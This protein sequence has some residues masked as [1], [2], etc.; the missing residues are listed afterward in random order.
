MTNHFTDM[1]NSDVIFVCGGNPAENHPAS[2]R[3]IMNARDKGAKLIVVD[4][5]YTRTAAV[6]D[7]YYPLR[8]GTDITLFGAII[9]YLIQNDLINHEYVTSYTNATWLIG[10]GYDFNDGM[11]S[12][13]TEDDKGKAKYDNTKWAYQVESETDWDTAP[14]APF[15]WA[16]AP[17]VPK[18]TT[19]KV[20]NVKKD[21]TMQDP[22]CVF[23][24]M[25]KHYERYTPQMVEDICG[26][27]KEQFKEVADA[28]GSTCT[29]DR[30]ATWLYAMGITQHTYGSQNIRAFSL[31]Q[32]LLGNI[33]IAGGGINALR[34]EANVQGS[35][36]WGLLADNLPSYLA[37][38]N[39]E[40]N[41]TLEAY[42]TKTT[43][44]AGY[45]SNRPK[46]LVSY[47]KEMYGPAA[48]LENEFCYQYLPKVEGSVN[49]TYM[50]IFE[51]LA[52]KKMNGML[53]FGQN[54]ALGGPNGNFARNA[55]KNLE[56]L[57]AIDLFMTDTAE[58]WNLPI[59]SGGKANPKAV[60][61]E[62]YFLPACSHI[63]KEGTTANSGR[64]IQWRYQAVKPLGESKD[65]GQIMSLLVEELKRLYAEEGGALP[66]AITDL[67][68]DYLDEN[69]H[70]S[71]RKAASA[72]NGYTT[73]DGKRILNLSKLQADGST[74]CIGWIYSGYFNN[75]D[76]DNPAD[77]PCGS[78]SREDVTISGG[79]G[80]L[81]SFTKWAWSWPMNRRVLYNR[82]STIKATG[83]A[84]NP[85]R[86]LVEWNP[87]VGNWDRNDVPDFGFQTAMPDGTN[88][89]NPPEKCPGFFMNSELVGRFF[90]PGL[91]DGPFPEHYEPIESP[92]KNKMS[93]QENNPA[94]LVLESSKRGSAKEYPIICTT[95]RVVEH[96]QTGASTRQSPWVAQSMPHMFLEI[97]V[98]L[99]KEKGIENGDKVEIFNNR[100]KITVFAMVTNRIR[101]FK[102]DGKDIYEVAM[103][104][105]WG[106][107][108]IAHGE[109]A[110]A[111]TPNYGDANTS[112]PESKAFLVDIRKVG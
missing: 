110:N 11:F 107:I 38:P 13:W 70:Y 86:M 48:T 55:M 51:Q 100:G 76:S 21:P 28:L 20:K 29:D 93:S 44:Y 99:A 83:K 49:Y 34:G 25:K 43:N 18:F 62:C 69:G 6:A 61:T 40:A 58:F 5:R 36:D 15:A 103:P 102:I 74:A 109:S 106:K 9:N 54:P 75:P 46:F 78:R 85:E 56:W 12:G 90:A 77:Q 32:M 79:K 88:V 72:A 104:W 42:L 31:V 60:D 26:M 71:A 1:A 82:A 17:G 108:G 87:T 98:G 96:W 57:V 4:P 3:H 91:K 24:L 10:D 89:G 59:E 68:W 73:V 2:M 8:S 63:E 81:G 39:A 80:G 66:G 45:W 105:H 27:T 23:Q 65:D 30:A 95:M 53:C 7:A 67:H 33:G 22:R 112:I 16:V 37:I 64:W 111:V 14:G 41:P 84:R 47:L 52:K 50:M 19:P 101:P 94:A 35:T 97:P 92:V